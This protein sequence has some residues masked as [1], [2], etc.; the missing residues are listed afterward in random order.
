MALT[1]LIQHIISE[2]EIHSIELRLINDSVITSEGSPCGGLFSHVDRRLTVAVADSDWVRFLAHEFGHMQ[3]A[4]DGLFGMSLDPLYKEPNVDD[5]YIALD[6]WLS[7]DREL[8]DKALKKHISYILACEMDA[9][10]R[11]VDLLTE[12]AIYPAEQYIQ[13]ANLTLYAYAYAY[14]HRRWVLPPMNAR[15]RKLVPKRFCQTAVEYLEIPTPLERAM[16]ATSKR[17]KR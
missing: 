6:E 15:M 17:T 1:D 12:H 11:A 10:K 14:K 8:S 13:E 3:Q 5:P 4:I 7:G 9:D 16:T 2:C